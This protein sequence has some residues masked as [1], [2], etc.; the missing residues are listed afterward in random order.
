[1]LRMFRSKSK[2]ILGWSKCE[3]NQ[4]RIVSSCHLSDSLGGRHVFFEFV[5]ILLPFSDFVLFLERGVGAN[6]RVNN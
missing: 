4:G 3:P 5:P 6:G 1:M 2:S